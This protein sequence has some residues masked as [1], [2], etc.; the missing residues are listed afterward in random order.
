MFTTIFSIG[1]VVGPV[2]GGLFVT[3][4][5]W[6]GIFLVNVPIGAI[7]IVAGSAVIPPGSKK[8]AETVDVFGAVLLGVLII[9]A[10]LGITS[11]G[12]AGG[13]VR[14][15]EFVLCEAIAVGS[16][17]LFLWHSRR[18]ASPFISS[19]LLYGRGIGIMNLINFLFGGAALGLGTLFPLYAQ[20]RFGI[21]LAVAGDL[22]TA[23]AVGT[24]CVA[25]LAVFALRRTGY[26]LPMLVGFGVVAAG[27]AMMAVPSPPIDPATWIALAAGLAGVGMGMSIPA[28]NNAI[29]QLAP[30]RVAGIAGLRGMFRQM[31]SII[32]ISVATAA[33]AA[34]TTHPGTSLGWTFLVAA[35]LLLCT[36]PLVL[37][38]PDHR[39]SW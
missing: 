25:A 22:L 30:A 17:V 31:G 18:A 27:L 6:R 7:L 10:M 1:T 28:S 24:I 14:S 21:S 15:V 34:H 12:S 38:I 32:A 5:S 26:R 23:R 39:G 20:D 4:W 13:S 2:L 16:L 29:L 35:G 36:L 19:A 33:A 9:S 37:L 11:L 3:Y 8:P